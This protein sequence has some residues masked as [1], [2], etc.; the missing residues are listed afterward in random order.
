MTFLRNFAS[1]SRRRFGKFF[2]AASIILM[3]TTATPSPTYAGMPV[4]VDFNPADLPHWIA[5]LAN[6]II[7]QAQLA[8][9]QVGNIM[10][11][12]VAATQVNLGQTA[13]MWDAHA[14]HETDEKA[15]IVLS[16]LILPTRSY[17]YP[18]FAQ[19]QWDTV[20]KALVSLES[21]FQ[22]AVLN[23]AAGRSSALGQL[24]IV[25]F[26]NALNGA[27]YD[28]EA[29]YYGGTVVGTRSYA[30]PSNFVIKGAGRSALLTINVGSGPN[31]SVSVT[32]APADAALMYCLRDLVPTDPLPATGS[33][34]ANGGVGNTDANQAVYDNQVRDQLARSGR[35][36]QGCLAEVAMRLQIG[37]S[38][39]NLPAN[40]TQVQ[41]AFQ[42]MCVYL[43]GGDAGGGKYQV[44]SDAQYN[45][46]KN[47]GV[48]YLQ[49]R[50]YFMCRHSSIDGVKT[51][52]SEGATTEEMD[53]RLSSPECVNE[54]TA[55]EES[56]RRFNYG[57]E[58]EDLSST[59]FHLNPAAR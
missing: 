47:N 35:R 40:L 26:K 58:A 52:S 50:Q 30:W 18:T 34:T 15:G 48:S 20:N 31:G 12:H 27:G 39:G 11:H 43:H 3:L 21:A 25:R 33:T 53:R 1:L 32:D 54:E 22:R 57:G 29:I 5:E 4:T 8:F 14:L 28:D 19:V 55:F 38:S 42:G 23:F 44:I 46:C 59:R 45:D 37:G 2:A 10:A 36:I 9:G 49:L 13:Q 24:E 56:Q 41:Q 6:W 7:Q 17:C 16:H 51:M